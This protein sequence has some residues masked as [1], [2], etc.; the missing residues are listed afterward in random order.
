M[1]EKLYISKQCRGQQCAVFSVSARQG[2]ALEGRQ[3]ENWR[4]GAATG[5]VWKWGAA[6]ELNSVTELCDY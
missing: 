5:T 4:C 1:K 6:T 2:G 3:E